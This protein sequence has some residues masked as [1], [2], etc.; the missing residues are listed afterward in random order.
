M[1][2]APLGNIEE[3]SIESSQDAAEKAAE[4]ARIAAEMEAAANEENILGLMRSGNAKYS[5]G[6]L[7]ES[8]EEYT[9]VVDIP[10]V[11]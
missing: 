5:A 3:L 10:Y 7:R 1:G 9:K 11:R 4:D 8:V 6:K 2:A